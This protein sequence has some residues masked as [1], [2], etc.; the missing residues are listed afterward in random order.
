MRGDSDRNSD[1]DKNSD[2]NNNSDRNSTYGNA[3]ANARY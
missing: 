3:Y 1:N 2:N